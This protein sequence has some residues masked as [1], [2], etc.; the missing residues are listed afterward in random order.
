M[1]KK[2]QKNESKNYQEEGQLYDKILRENLLELFLPLVAEQLNFT[3]KKVTPLVDKQPTTVLRETDSFLLIETDSETEPKFILHIEFERKDNPN[4]IY[5]M[6]E[7]HGIELRKY[8]LPIKHVVVY[9]GDKTPKMRTSLQKEEIFESFTLVNI[10]ET[11]PQ[12]WLNYDEPERIIMAILG[13]YEKENA[14]IILEAILSKLRKVCKSDDDLKKFTKQLIIISRMRNL[15]EL[16]TKIS[17]KMPILIDIEKDYL[18]KLGLEKGKKLL[19]EAEEALENLKADFRVEAIAKAKAE[20]EK[21]AKAKVVAEKAAKEKAVAIVKAKAEAKKV[22]KA[23][24]KAKVEAEKADKAKAAKE[25]AAAIA[26]AQAIAEKAAKEKAAAIAQAQA[27][28]EKAAKEKA[29]A[30][31][32]AKTATEKAI[33]KMKQAGLEAATIMDFLNLDKPTFDLFLMEIEQNKEL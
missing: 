3:I 17:N 11:S 26:Q 27:V 23:I 13:N 28:A 31:A 1:P 7:Y 25:K 10:H 32:Q 5:R 6:V 12:S 30:I 14:K 21:A 22:A 33:T 16:T 19:L 8:K 4:M 2:N 9:L 20:A 18:Y 24:A 29:E 15:E